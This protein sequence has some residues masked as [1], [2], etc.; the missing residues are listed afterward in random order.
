M[1]LTGAQQSL[2]VRL[3]AYVYDDQYSDP[4]RRARGARFDRCDTQDSQCASTTV[5]ATSFAAT[6]MLNWYLMRRPT[7]AQGQL[8]TPARPAHSRLSRKRKDD[9]SI[10]KTCETW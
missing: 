6:F 4:H 8:G 9:A 3:Y 7:T 10:S 1:L 2:A 5:W